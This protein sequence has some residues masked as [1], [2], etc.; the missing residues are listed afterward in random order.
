MIPRRNRRRVVNLGKKVSKLLDLGVIEAGQLVLRTREFMSQVL[1]MAAA[2]FRPIAAQKKID[3]EIA[4]APTLPE[5]IRPIPI[6]YGRS[7]TCSTT[8]SS[9]RRPEGR[10]DSGAGRTAASRSR[11]RIPAWGFR[12]SA[13]CDLR[14]IRACAA[15]TGSSAQEPASAWPSR[16]IVLAHGGD[17]SGKPPRPGRLSHRPSDRRAATKQAGGILWSM[18]EG[19]DLAMALSRVDGDASDVCGSLGM[20]IAIRVPVGRAVTA[21]RRS[22]RAQATRP[23]ALKRARR[24]SVTG[25]G[26]RRSST[27]IS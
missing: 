22:P 26:T 19:T 17:R 8:R 23:K 9:S 18:H 20:G 27:S 12:R 10:F 2:A 11:S 25:G 7:S 15:Q 16:R 14:Q 6:G 21:A 5:M 24:L 4:V 13:H 3:F 1:L